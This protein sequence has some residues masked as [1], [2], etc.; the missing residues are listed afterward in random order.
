M[1]RPDLRHSILF[2][3]A[4]MFVA[5]GARAQTGGI[6]A[7]GRP[8][9][10]LQAAFDA[11]Q[12]NGI[13]RIEPG[14]YREGGILKKDRDGV[15]ISGSPGVVFD[16]VAV[17]GKA[18]FVIQSDNVTIEGVACR[19][20]KVGSRNGACV[21]FE[22][23]N[24]TLRNVNF[25][26]SENGILTWDKAGKILIEDSV[27]E[28]NGKAGRAHGL[29]ISGAKQLIVRRTRIVGSKDQGHGIKA[30]AENVLIENSVV[31]SL[32][33]D[34]SYLIDI[35]NGGMAIIRNCLLVEG[36]NTVNWSLLTFGVEGSKFDRN[37]LRFE[38]NV[39]IVD[40]E[41][42]ANF[43]NLADGMPAP[44]LRGNVVVGR[45]NYDGWPR[46]SNY[47]FDSREDLNWPDAPALPDV[48]L[49]GGR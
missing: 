9:P 8:M 16:G 36:A 29:Y 17:G 14:I 20:I 5:T 39:V 46:D 25:S 38:K 42:G 32:E 4:L 41:G 45:A 10:T 11:V 33:G 28:G 12:P 24:L 2:L 31:A 43:I 44:L 49:S 22:S 26:H 19:N 48:D 7:D 6:Y 27:F 23:T 34:D 3:F 47:F 40:R 37:L 18:A 35:P 21:R 30:R 1:R 13:V 15:L